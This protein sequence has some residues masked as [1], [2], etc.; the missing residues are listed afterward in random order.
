MKKQEIFKKRKRRYWVKHKV[1]DLE[2]AIN[3]AMLTL[4]NKDVRG[5]YER[6]FI[7]HIAP[8]DVSEMNDLICRPYDQEI[9]LVEVKILNESKYVN[10]SDL[11]AKIEGILEC[12]LR[13]STD[14]ELLLYAEG[15]Y[16]PKNNPECG[17]Y[18]GI[19]EIIDYRQIWNILTRILVVKTEGTKKHLFYK[20]W[21]DYPFTVAIKGD[22]YIFAVKQSK[23]YKN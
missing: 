2:V 15:Q 23:I 22:V 4:T 14:E 7:I 5:L 9:K 11:R 18:G 16:Y 20:R 8:S 12:V 10:I 19:G 13:Y 3:C 1:G 21:S 17:V 6:K